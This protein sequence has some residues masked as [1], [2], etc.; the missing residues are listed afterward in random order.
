[1]LTLRFPKCAAIV[2]PIA[3]RGENVP[4]AKSFGALHFFLE[5][6]PK[7]L[8]RAGS[9]EKI[10]SRHLDGLRAADIMKLMQNSK[11]T[12]SRPLVGAIAAGMLITAAVLFLWLGIPMN[13]GLAT[14]RGALVRLGI[15]MSAAWLAL[16][17]KGRP[18]A[19]AKINPT[20]FA[21]GF[22][23][24]LALPRLPYRVLLPLAAILLAAG[25][26]LRPRPLKRPPRQ[27]EPAPRRH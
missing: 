21:A 27:I 26:L 9:R 6:A 12:I 3:D 5:S 15:V 19:W 20:S 24:L 18:A 10:V 1:M 25:W 17:S 16:P 23:V 8:T 7:S 4:D 2:E 13:A 11:N 14:W 22:L